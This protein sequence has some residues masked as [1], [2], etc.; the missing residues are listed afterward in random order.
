[1]GAT[2]LTSPPTTSPWELQEGGT[3]TAGIFLGLLMLNTR[4]MLFAVPAGAGDF[5]KESAEN[6]FYVLTG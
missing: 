5:Q 1:M 3:Q 4:W 6:E 2:N